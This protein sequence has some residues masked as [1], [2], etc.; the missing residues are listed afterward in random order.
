MSEW[1]KMGCFP[2]DGRWCLVIGGHWQRPAYARSTDGKGGIHIETLMTVHG[3][4]E[5]GDVAAEKHP[6]HWMPLPEPPNE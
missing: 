3:K 4:V 2:Q 1:K 6:T 5:S